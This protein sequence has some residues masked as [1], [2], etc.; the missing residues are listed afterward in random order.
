MILIQD[1]SSLMG[2]YIIK[3]YFI[4]EMVHVDFKFS[5]SIM[6]FQLWDILVSTKPWS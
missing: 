6:T 4:F 2:S 1:S 5:T 3:D